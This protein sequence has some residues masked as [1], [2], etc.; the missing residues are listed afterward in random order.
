[1]RY[2]QD[3]NIVFDPIPNIQGSV[4]RTYKIK[5]SFYTPLINHQSIKGLRFFKHPT[6][7]RNRNTGEAE[8]VENSFSISEYS[9]GMIVVTGYVRK[10]TLDLMFNDTI[11][12]RNV[13]QFVLNFKTINK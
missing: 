2:N 4:G 12:R 13:R 7:A 1:M 11:R 8:I 10:Q 6:Y 9:T 5:G 3:F